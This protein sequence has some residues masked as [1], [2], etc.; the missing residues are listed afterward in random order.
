MGF[1]G[2]SCR[3]NPEKK[4]IPSFAKRV[5]YGQKA[6]W[7]MV[8]NI[9]QNSSRLSLAKVDFSRDSSLRSIATD[10]AL[11]ITVQSLL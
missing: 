8:S 5:P 9:F 4:L 1:D 7:G 3:Q 6:G 2:S 11:Q 10:P